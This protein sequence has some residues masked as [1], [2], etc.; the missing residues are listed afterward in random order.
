MGVKRREGDPSGR[1]W[2]AFLCTLLLTSSP[3]MLHRGVLALGVDRGSPKRSPFG[4]RK[5]SPGARG[6]AAPRNLVFYS[7]AVGAPAGEGSSLVTLPCPDGIFIKC[8][9]PGRKRPLE[10]TPRC[11]RSGAGSSRAPG[12][13]EG[14]PGE[15]PLPRP[16]PPDTK[17]A[18][19]A[20]GAR[21]C[22]FQRSAS[23]LGSAFVNNLPFF[24]RPGRGIAPPPMQIRR[25]PRSV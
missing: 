11:R 1:S 23:D 22:Q 12:S 8:R 3:T 4:G 10:G 25:F 9:S 2:G 21:V 18:Q 20:R 24:A 19:E 16:G 13:P 5:S 6:G 14:I 17:R 7:G 15:S